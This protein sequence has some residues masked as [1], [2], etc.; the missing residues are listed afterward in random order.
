MRSLILMGCLWLLAIAG[1]SQSNGRVRSGT[2]LRWSVNGSVE[3]ME[4]DLTQY[5]GSNDSNIIYTRT[6]TYE[7]AT[8]GNPH[9]TRFANVQGLCEQNSVQLNWVARQQF[10]ADRYDI[11]QS[12]DGR[13]WTSI[14]MVPANRTDFGE[15]NY[16]FNYTKNAGNVFF[17]IN[18]LSTTGERVYSSVIESPCSNN[19]YRSITPNPV[20][21]TTTVRIGSPVA[22]KAKMMLVNSS[23]VIVQVRDATMLPGTNQLPVDMSSL[24]TGFYSLF[25]QWAG[26]RSDVMKLM[27]Q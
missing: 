10:N 18:A 4:G 15:A 9:L 2:P 17:R 27:K 3:I 8:L 5:Y 21:S 20:Y 19:A 23:G 22:T 11:E 7:S 6:S 12:T 24:P 13:N 1:Y 25:I 16:N 14:G 26:G